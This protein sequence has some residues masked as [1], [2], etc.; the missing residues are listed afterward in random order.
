MR[1]ILIV[2]DEP[3]LRSTLAEFLATKCVATVQEAASGDEAMSLLQGGATPKLLVTDLR[4][5]GM[6]GLDLIRRAKAAHPTL[7]VL[8]I[9][10]EMED[11]RALARD[12]GA[13]EV[14]RKPF[15]FKALEVVALRLLSE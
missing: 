11:Q 4:M 6:S 12:A 14:L 7:R 2:D 15:D 13:D 10:G 3:D 1:R 9:T 5:P 8:A